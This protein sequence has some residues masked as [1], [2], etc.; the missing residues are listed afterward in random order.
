MLF[1]RQGQG[2]ASILE[3]MTSGPLAALERRVREELT[4]LDP[5]SRPWR[6]AEDDVLDVLIVGAG[7]GGLS[8][9]FAL[10]RL[11]IANILI[12]DRS[13][14]GLEGPWRSFARMPTLRTYKHLTGPDLGIPSLTPRAWFEAV[15]GAAAFASA[16]R[17]PT[18]DWAAYLDWYRR[19]TGA[20][21]QNGVEVTS[22]RPDA[23]GVTVETGQGPF[24]ARHVVLANGMDGAGAWHVPPEVA[25]AL[26]RSAYA[27]TAEPI[28][29]AALAGRRVLVLGAGASAFDAALAAEAAGA[30]SV[31]LLARRPE[32][33][34]ANPFIWMEQD[35]FLHFFRSLDDATRWRF[36]RHFHRFGQPPTEATLEAVAASDTVSVLAG[37]GVTRWRWNGEIQAELTSG[38]ALAADFLILGTGVQWGLPLRPE[39]AAI[40]PATLLWR[41]RAPPGEEEP[42]LAAQPY[43]GEDFELLEREP[44][45]LPGL[46]RIRL[47]NYAALPSMGLTGSAIAGLRCGVPHLARGIGRD[48]FRAEAGAQL[49]SLEAFLRGE[50]LPPF[51]SPAAIAALEAK[52]RMSR[53]ISASA[54]APS[55]ATIRPIS[56]E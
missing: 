25:A 29:P 37:R 55:R 31:R 9:A 5:Q 19:M 35:G 42:S 52:P 53:A 45:A 4:L 38:E 33:R 21:V 13:L 17:I 32:L 27:D 24:R 3:D 6:P 54:P 18:P 49:R 1:G 8:I 34:R 23:E 16:T 41:D 36:A 48:L 46:S 39:L 15:H 14:P 40:A 10:R 43:L 26:P 7:Q 2:I 56:G 11:G 30:V 22:L 28:D 51:D 47:F 20:R 44:G 12:V 50:E